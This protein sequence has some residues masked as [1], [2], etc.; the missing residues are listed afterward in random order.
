MTTATAT[1]SRRVPRISFRG[2][3]MLFMAVVM[4]HWVEH[5][6]QAGQIF[7]L[8]W[9]RPEAGGALGLIWPSLV[10]S[11]WLHYGYAIVMLVGLYVLR[12]GFTGT[13]RTWWL[14]AFGIQVW[15]HVEHLLL[16]VQAQTHT[17]FFGAAK[18]T[19]IAQLF[20]ERAELHLFYNALVTAPMLAA[21]YLQFYAA[22]RSSHDR[23]VR[24]AD[25]AARRSAP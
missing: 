5:L 15:H 14:T 2:T 23:T 19:S 18:P 8:G 25:R 24:R 20:V 16:L 6:L 22:H 17:T 7:L 11:E 12:G 13:A 1:V 10:T 3:V 21:V 9:P 4:A